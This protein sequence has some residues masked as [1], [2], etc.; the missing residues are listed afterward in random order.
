M[1]KIQYSTRVVAIVISVQMVIMFVFI[2]L[3][4]FNPSPFKYPMVFFVI[5]IIIIPIA[6]L[7]IWK[8]KTEK[9][10]RQNASLKYKAL[11]NLLMERELMSLYDYRKN[12]HDYRRKYLHP[13]LSK[14]E[15]RALET[16]FKYFPQLHL[17]KSQLELENDIQSGDLVV[18]TSKYIFNTIILCTVG[19]GFLFPF[20]ISIAVLI[21][22]YSDS[23]MNTFSGGSE[24][25]AI[26]LAIFTLPV[27][28]GMLSMAMHY[29]FFFIILDSHGIYYKKVGKPK[30][31][32]WE[33]VAKIEG[34]PRKTEKCIRIHLKANEKI[35]FGEASYQFQDKYLEYYDI[36]RM[37]KHLQ[38]TFLAFPSFP[39]FTRFNEFL[40]IG[41]FD[42]RDIMPL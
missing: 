5:P 10:I 11:Y 31:I 12:L 8:N 38:C 20:V 16:C 13:K 1:V 41:Q 24:G 15:K 28:V 2:M 35:R 34:Y 4:A 39:S 23:T 40:Q 6:G 25:A 27:S 33:D 42:T 7:S 26:F 21:I 30:V 32:L 36:F 14:R 17:K 18:I 29:R 37:F 22:S 19:L 9:K 3:L